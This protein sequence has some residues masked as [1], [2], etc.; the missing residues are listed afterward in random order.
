MSSGV[1]FSIAVVRDVA[2]IL[3]T[4]KSVLSAISDL[5][6]LFSELKAGK[7]G[8]RK[9]DSMEKKL[10][11]LVSWVNETEEILFANLQFMVTFNGYL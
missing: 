4:R 9:L 11:F 7:K 3:S 10:L 8:N 6:R 2:S 1:Q 5:F